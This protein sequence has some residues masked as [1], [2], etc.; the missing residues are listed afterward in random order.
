MNGKFNN[1]HLIILCAY[2][3]VVF[4]IGYLAS[5]KTRNVSDYILGGREFNPY[6][7]ALGAGASDMSGWLMLGLPGAVY[8][9]GIGQIWMPIGLLIG[10]Y[11]NWT[12]VAKRLR[13]YSEIAGNA[14]TLPVYL[15][16]RFNDKSGILRLTMAIT[17]LIF[18]T[19]YAAS[20]LAGFALLFKVLFNLPYALGL[21]FGFFSIVFYTCIG[22]FIAVNWV[23]VFQGSL[24]FFALLIL[25]LSIWLHLQGGN[26]IAARLTLAHLNYTNPV[27]NISLL[28]IFSLLGW[29]LGYFGQPHILVRFMAARNSRH[30]NIAK[31]VCMVWMALCLIGAILV[32]LFGA[33]LY[34]H[35]PLL[36]PEAIFL[37]AAMK[38]FAPAIAGVLFAAVLSAI[39]S[40]ISA[41]LLVCSS[42][43]IEDIYT[44]FFNTHL[45]VKKEV[46]LNRIAIVVIALIALLLAV[47]PKSTILELVSYAWAGLGA[48]FGPIILFSLYWRRMTRNGALFG[49]VLGGIIVVLW[50]SL[51]GLGGIF[52]LYELIPGFIACSLGIYFG[53][54]L[55]TRYH[56]LHK[57]VLQQHDVFVTKMH[58][59]E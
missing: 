46:R 15:S 20:G 4:F 27:K 25:P 3:L 42:A 17:S 59:N 48:A 58:S 22:G 54:M 6:I 55:E 53:S 1:M 40:T 37:R 36:K 39:M 38:L 29:G 47:D 41:Q 13:I 7:T 34:V 52:Q 33:A 30:M 8:V 12:F 18:F 51:N 19:V 5:R 50:K 56:H 49:M 10:A 35:T 14:L 9:G 31:N 21:W 43:L 26:D 57:K 16:N 28:S 32:G 45:S 23:D 2:F 24:M 11:L 44:K